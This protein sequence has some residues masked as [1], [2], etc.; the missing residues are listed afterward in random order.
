MS[1]RGVILFLTLIL[2]SLSP[3]EPSPPL[4]KS[5]VSDEVNLEGRVL[6]LGDS[7]THAGYYVSMI[8]MA[9]RERGVRPFPEMINLGLPSETVTGLSEPE[10]P[11]P[12]PD[13]HERLD[14]A[15][16]TIRPDLVFAC[17]GMNDSIYHPF[18]EERFRQYQDGIGLLIEK[19]RKS[20]AKLVLMTPPPFD[21]LRLRNQGKLKPAGVEAYSWKE[22]YE[23]YDSEVIARYGAW[24]LRQ[25]KRVDG[26]IDFRPA[27]VERLKKERMGDPDFTYSNDGVHANA[28][29]H[30]VMARTIM[31]ALGLDPQTKVPGINS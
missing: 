4:G 24:I 30:R 1:Y 5:S 12:R 3:A 23:H 6:F 27:I 21:P 10:H 9:L 22:I 13:V 11:W 31:A 16:A 28:D 14:R 17:Y 2:P 15:L 25:R 20:G 8:D 7:I 18:S 19:V 26:V 29:G